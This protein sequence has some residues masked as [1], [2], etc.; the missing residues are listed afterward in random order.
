[1]CRWAQRARRVPR[2]A[3][4]PDAY[5]RS[6]LCG[7]DHIN[8]RLGC[9]DCRRCVNCYIMSVWVK[10]YRRYSCLWLVAHMRS[11]FPHSP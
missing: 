11:W 5:V 6:W 9:I 3:A 10:I 4:L 1:M 7:V 8:S 2:E